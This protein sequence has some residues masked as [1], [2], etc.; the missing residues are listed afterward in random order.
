MLLNKCC[1][2]LWLFG[3]G[4]LVGVDWLGLIGYEKWRF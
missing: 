1:L 4:C 3:W 2:F